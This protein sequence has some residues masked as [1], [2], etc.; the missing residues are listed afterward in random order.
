[1]VV[2]SISNAISKTGSLGSYFVFLD[3]S[4]NKR[5]A[6]QFL[7][8]HNTAETGIALKWLFP[9]RLSFK[10][11]IPPAVQTLYWSQKLENYL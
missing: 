11:D 10:T 2:I 8:I 7:H 5:L 3:M 6:M 1:M 4:S 9:P